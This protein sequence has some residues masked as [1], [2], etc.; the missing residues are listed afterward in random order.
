[1][2]KKFTPSGRKRKAATASTTLCP[3]ADLA[4]QHGSTVAVVAL[5]TGGLRRRKR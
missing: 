4:N 3:N 5:G 2:P 1:M